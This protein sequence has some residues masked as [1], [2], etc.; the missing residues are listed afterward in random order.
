[1]SSTATMK[2]RSLDPDAVS[3]VHPHVIVS[4]IVSLFPSDKA[5]QTEQ[6]LNDTSKVHMVEPMADD[7][8]SIVSGS[9]SPPRD[10]SGRM[11]FGRM[12]LPD[13]TPGPTALQN[14]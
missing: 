7:T 3:G 8:S 11:R 5:G 13:L 14:T 6:D 2:W 10:E 12:R 9:D 1:M 4:G